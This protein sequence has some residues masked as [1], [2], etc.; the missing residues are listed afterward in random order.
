MT[1]G[2]VAVV[3]STPGVD[4]DMRW[5][6]STSGHWIPLGPLYAT[7]VA[8]LNGLATT[9]GGTV[10]VKLADNLV[11]GALAITADGN[12]YRYTGS[13]GTP[14]MSISG[15]VPVFPQSTAGFA[16]SAG[17][18]LTFTNA[19]AFS[20]NGIFSAVFAKYQIKVQIA[21]GTGVTQPG[22]RL[23]GGGVDVIAATYYQEV[24]YGAGATPSAVAQLGQTQMQVPGS[25]DYHKFT[26]EMDNPFVALPTM[27]TYNGTSWNSSGG[28]GSAYTSGGAQS[29]ATSYDGF[30][31][32]ANTNSFSGTVQVFG[33]AG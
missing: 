27:H 26:L 16:S 13:T 5:I 22:F 14:W 19:T 24:L 10:N 17:S 3:A 25:G 8:S 30:T 23:R 29:S 32:L 28:A 33:Y 6:Y 18:I 12:V 15:L 21:G 7:N 1:I 4:V 9:V 2:S 20:I 11:G 31:M